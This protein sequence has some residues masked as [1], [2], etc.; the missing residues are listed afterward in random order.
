MIPAM[1]VCLFGPFELQTGPI[2]VPELSAPKLRAL[3]AVL[4]LQGK[5]PASREFLC[6]LL[7]PD[8][9]AARARANLRQSLLIL[10]KSFGKHLQGEGEALILVADSDVAEFQQLAESS[11]PG[12]WRAAAL[13]YRAPLL[14][15]FSADSEPLERWL[16]V[17]RE[18]MQRLAQAL[19]L[20]LLDHELAQGDFPAALAAGE[21]LL[22][23]D[24]AC[25]AAHCGL[26]RVHQAR[27]ARDAVVR[28]YERLRSALADHLGLRPSDESRALYDRLVHSEAAAVPEASTPGIAVMPFVNIPDDPSQAYFADGLAEEILAGLTRFRS[29]R[30]IARHSTHAYRERS[31]PTPQIAREL[32][33]HYFL[34]GSVRRSGERVRV[35]VLLV[36]AQS[37]QQLFAERFDG[38]LADVFDL[39]D[40]VAQA[41][42]ARL[43]Q[44]IDADT[45]T[46]SRRKAPDSL[47]AYDL[48]LQGLARLRR[49]TVADDAA[50]RHL[51]EQAL[52]LDPNYARAWSG[53]S[54][55]HFNEWSCQVWNEWE[56][57]AT[58]A[59]DYARRALELDDSDHLTQCVVGKVLLYRRQFE[60]AEH[61]LDRSLALNSNDADT[62]AQIS[63]AMTQLG[64][65]E[66]ALL[67]ADRAHR[68]NPHAPDWYW[69]MTAV[70]PL[71]IGDYARTIS[72]LERAPERHVDSP[73]LL[74]F[75]CA[76]SGQMSKAESYAALY[77]GLFTQ[78]ITFGRTP[79]PDEP[80][81]WMFD[82]SPFR[83]PAP[84]QALF[85]R[86]D[87][88]GFR[89]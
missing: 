43:A 59:H 64:R 17:E 75:A 51:F 4:C 20:R 41:V 57:R 42:V 89:L 82:I 1:R 11:S 15:G 35:S 19:T 88:V 79:A 71:L 33:V 78:R 26:M 30:V 86:L 12:Q 85:G 5:R 25:E 50:A 73:A 27:G 29:L 37:S 72:E 24:A 87:A 55:S 45:V 67:L 8:A 28:Q 38:T 80:L 74:A 60:V 83:D 61:H 39:Q 31:V 3:A 49:G 84:M 47:V 21:R 53:L 32:G 54:M 56:M 23:W 58:L 46:R 44:S 62:L 22:R 16:Q 65:V 9:E 68:L 7:W 48:W 77:R 34:E 10:R 40:R 2:P 14:D 36:D 6:G 18:R 69:G 63:I 76:L 13:L 81:R 70:A 66:E 52:A